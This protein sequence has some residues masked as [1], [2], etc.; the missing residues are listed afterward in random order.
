MAAETPGDRSLSLN[1]RKSKVLLADG[2]G[3]K[4]LVGEQRTAMD[5]I[6]LKVVHQGM[7]AVRIP[8]GT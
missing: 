7:R 3:P 5:D 1:R 8:V 2:V 6:G 4:H